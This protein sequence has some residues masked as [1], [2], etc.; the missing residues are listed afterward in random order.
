MDS[1]FT[2]GCS[3]RDL[4]RRLHV[5]EAGRED[6]L[7]AGGH[8]VADDA[9]GVRPLGHVLDEGRLHARTEARPARPA[10]LLVLAHPAGVGDGRD[11]DEA[12][13]ERLVLLRVRRE[14]K[15]G[16]RQCAA[17]RFLYMVVLYM[18]PEF[19]KEKGRRGA[20]FCVF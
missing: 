18:A 13:L 12:D 19:D 11:I 15:T 20:T 17:A 16:G 14:R 10:A 7:V 8:E 4:Q 2:S 6:Q 5:A 9:L 1:N 3:L